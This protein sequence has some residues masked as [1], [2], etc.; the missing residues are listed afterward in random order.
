MWQRQQIA[1]ITCDVLNYPGNGR[2][3]VFLDD[4]TLEQL[5]PTSLQWPATWAAGT[6]WVVPDL[7]R[8]CWIPDLTTSGGVTLEDHF[9]NEFLS[10]LQT[11]VVSSTQALILSGVGIGGQ[12]A[13]RLSNSQPTR[14]FDTYTINPALDLHLWYGLET[15]LDERYPNPE[16]VRQASMTVQ[17]RAHAR[18]PKIWFCTTEEEYYLVGATRFCE[19]LTALGVP[20]HWERI[21]GTF[22]ENYFLAVQKML[23]VMGSQTRLPLQT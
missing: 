23:V 9:I 12:A 7:A 4:P 14:Q 8:T 16:A 21:S 1:Q 13:V 10:E 19:K 15:T 6:N 3:I 20:H 18:L 2:T 11:S 5:V 17:F 22:E